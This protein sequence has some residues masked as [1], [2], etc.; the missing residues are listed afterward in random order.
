MLTA[1]YRLGGDVI[2]VEVGKGTSVA[3]FFVHTELLVKH[4]EVFQAIL[5]H[6]SEEGKERAIPLSEPC[7][8]AFS[9]FHS[10]L[11]TG[12]VYS[13]DRNEQASPDH[14][15]EWFRL[16]QGWVLGAMLVS[17]TYKDAIADAVLHKAITQNV[18]PTEMFYNIYPKSRDGSPFRKLLVDLAVHWAHDLSPEKRVSGAGER[19]AAALEYFQD[20]AMALHRLHWGREK[21]KFNRLLRKGRSCIYHEHGEDEPC[22][23]TL[24]D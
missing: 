1:L 23:K 14:D 11:Y 22:Y 18:V 8:D 12:K 6:T 16:S 5:T 2:C 10:F 7:A 4:S 17:G 15:E 13:G 20:V 3:K 21:V 9:D 24:F 19:R